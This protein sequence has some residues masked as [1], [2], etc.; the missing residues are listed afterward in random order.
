MKH[1]TT[2]T[3]VIAAVIIV[4]T[5]AT[6]AGAQ[7]LYDH[8][9]CYK[10][11]D[12]AKFLAEVD[13]TALQAEFGLEHCKVK[14]KA[15]LFC[16]PVD[17]DVTAFT[18]KSKN[19][20]PPVAYDGPEYTNDRVCYKIKCPPVT[21]GP[22]QITDQFGTRNVEKFKPMLLCAPA[23]KGVP[24]TTTTTVLA[25]NGTP[26]SDPNTCQSGNCVDGYCCGSSACGTCESCAVGGSEGECTFVAAGTDPHGDCPAA[27]CSGDTLYTNNTCDGAGTCQL[28]GPVSCAPYL[29]DVVT[30][31]CTTTCAVD[32]DCA[33]GAFCSAGMCLWQLPNGSACGASN[34]CQ[35][36]ICWNGSCGLPSG[37]SCTTGSECI[38]GNCVSGV[39]Q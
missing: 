37:E 18:D 5:G 28:G 30:L 39:C 3:A 2:R 31:Q 33:S 19:G 34:Q 38:S 8:M 20:I 35:S 1:V 27:V 12:Q 9:K 4:L 24:V 7:P 23:V 29:C 21:V 26:C 13:L 10:V 36:G 11:K 25:A 17:K 14:G 15:K 32:A 6:V 16:I 22:T